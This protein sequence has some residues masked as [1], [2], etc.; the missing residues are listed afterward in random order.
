MW[1]T[2]TTMV[3]RLADTP[4][5]KTS[6]NGKPYATV[7]I[8]HTA[9]RFDKQSNTWIDGDETALSGTLFGDY[10]VNVADSLTSGTLVIACGRL[11]ENR[12][13]D[14]EGNRRSKLTMEIEEIG[15]SLRWDTA[16]VNRKRGGGS[17]RPA[18]PSTP[19]RAPEPA[20]EEPPF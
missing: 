9:R 2:Y 7:K 3:G 13:Q 15:P 11:R 8:I 12:W 4:E 20:R 16:T 1:D 10:A 19:S 18:Q 6:R 5:L 17:Q 14:D